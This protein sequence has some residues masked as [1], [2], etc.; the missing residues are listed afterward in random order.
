[1]LEGEECLVC[2]EKECDFVTRCGHFY[3]FECLKLLN[4]RSLLSADMRNHQYFCHDLDWDPPYGNIDLVTHK[5][6]CCIS[7]ISHNSILEGF[8]WNPLLNWD[9]MSISWDQRSN[10]LFY[11]ISTKDFNLF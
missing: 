11:A 1:M 10:V 3:H 5:C 6:P 8:L 4:E 2:E 7:K 9:E